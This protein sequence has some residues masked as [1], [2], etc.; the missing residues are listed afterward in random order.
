MD[1]RRLAEGPLRR[2]GNPS[3]GT[4]QAATLRHQIPK[5]PQEPASS[6]WLVN[7]AMAGQTGLFCLPA[8]GG[9]AS[10]YRPWRKIAPPWLSVLPVLLPAREA[11]LDEPAVTSMTAV[12]EAALPHIERHAPRRYALF[13]HSMG[14]IIAFELARKLSA[15]G[16]PPVRL[17]VSGAAAPHYGSQL[18]RLSD[19][20]MD[21]ILDVMIAQCGVSGETREHAELVDL[22]EPAL[23]GDL[24]IVESY[25]YGAGP[26][27]SCPITVLQ[28]EE[29]GLTRPERAGAWA[30]QTRGSL[31]LRTYPGDHSFLQGERAAVV[32]DIV[33]DL[34]ADGESP[35]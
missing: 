12:V 28:G 17:F 10:D 19:R 6:P 14:A 1:P 2:P 31:I 11:R 18:P 26:M 29:D 13:G 22:L 8:S 24:K 9:G 4:P 32:S 7:R 35:K 20:P 15:R 21:E 27:L 16:R 33:R 3:R 25:V 5:V 34:E 23:R 30:Y